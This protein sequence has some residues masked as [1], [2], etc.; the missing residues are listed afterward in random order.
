[1]ITML[2]SWDDPGGGQWQVGKYDL[3][4]RDTRESEHEVFLKRG[5]KV[6]FSY[7]F[8]SCRGSRYSYYY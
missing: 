4:L 7:F 2:L 6:G 3:V 8:S 5:M 1:M